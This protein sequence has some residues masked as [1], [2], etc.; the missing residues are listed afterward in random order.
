VS[1]AGGV[2]GSD[3]GCESR[4]IRAR[5]GGLRC[6]P[7]HPRSLPDRD[8]YASCKMGRLRAQ[9][10]LTPR[11]GLSVVLRPESSRMSPSDLGVLVLATRGAAAEEVGG[12]GAVKGNTLAAV[13]QTVCTGVRNLRTLTRVSLCPIPQWATLEGCTAVALMA[14]HDDTEQASGQCARACGA[15]TR[16]RRACLWRAQR[17]CATPHPQGHSQNS[18]PWP[19]NFW[20]S[21]CGICVATNLIFRRILSLKYYRILYAKHTVG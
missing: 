1:R 18:W 5:I 10:R 20:R 6:P 17:A 2:L 19:A 3:I 15:L 7:V 8:F 12:S 4:K 13:E 11:K 21:E 16:V 9:Q 14:E